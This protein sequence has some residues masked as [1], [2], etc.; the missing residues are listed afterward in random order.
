[1]VF[2]MFEDE[3]AFWFE[4]SFL[5][6]QVRDGRQFLQGVWRIGKDKV[7]LLLARLYKAKDIA[8]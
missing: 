2:A 3:D 6:D 7:K 1:M 5:K 8:F 4:E